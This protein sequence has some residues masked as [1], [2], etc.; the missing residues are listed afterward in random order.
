MIGFSDKINALVQYLKYLAFA[1][2]S[3]GHGLH[4][5]F[6]YEFTKKVLFD[7]KRYSDYEKIKAVAKDLKKTDLKI[8]VKELGG[9]SRVFSKESRKVSMVLK[10]SSVRRKYCQ[11]LYRIARFYQAENIIEL[12]TSVG[13]S[14]LFM[15]IGNRKGQ[16]ITLEGNKSLIEIAKS[17]SVKL[18]IDNINFIH[19]NFDTQLPK[20]LTNKSKVD[21]AFI[22]G[23]H[24]YEATL[25]YYS[26]IRN[27][28]GK[29]FIIFDDIYWSKG[30]QKAW[31]AIKAKEH[32]CIDLYHFGIV[33]VGEQLTPGHYRIRF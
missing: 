24:T 4:S 14:S 23:N 32:V 3:G 33:I 22:D 7:K 25:K 1:R 18:N 10:S 26:I 13:M 6:M 27:H 17:S 19:G 31:T 29:G 5:P 21:L 12:G 20:I 11:L 30:M 15:A 8:E 16:V 2:H 28:I 9:G